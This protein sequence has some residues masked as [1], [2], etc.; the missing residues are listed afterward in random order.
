MTF[1]ARISRRCPSLLYSFSARRSCL[2]SFRQTLLRM[3]TWE[4]LIRYPAISTA[5]V[6]L[7]APFLVFLSCSS[8]VCM[9]LMMPIVI[10]V[11]TPRFVCIHFCRQRAA[12]MRSFADVA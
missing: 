6:V 12:R 4:R 7:A 2:R 1:S 5:G 11:V 10:L 3:V 9:I 8:P